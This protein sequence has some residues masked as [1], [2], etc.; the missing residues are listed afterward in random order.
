MSGLSCTLV[1][2]MGPIS[3]SFWLCTDNPEAEFQNHVFASLKQTPAW[4]AG[5][6]RV[7]CRGPVLFGNV[8]VSALHLQFLVWRAGT[9]PFT[10]VE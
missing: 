4:H 8:G 10:A 9:M 3:A 6:L 5:A 2:S 1:N 7:G